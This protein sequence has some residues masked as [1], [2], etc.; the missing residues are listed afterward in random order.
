MLNPSITDANDD[1][2]TIRCAVN[3]AKSWDYGVQVVN[4]YTF[5]SKDP[6]M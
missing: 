5:R 6:K 4:L 1:D 3:F 2:P